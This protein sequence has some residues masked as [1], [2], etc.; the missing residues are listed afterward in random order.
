MKLFGSKINIGGKGIRIAAICLAAVLVL[1]AALC[2]YTYANS[3]IFMRVSAGDISLGGKTYDEALEAIKS[4]CASRYENA[5]ITIRLED[6]ATEVVSS[7]ELKLAYDAEKTAAAAMSFGHEGGFFARIGSVLKTI[8]AGHELE[9]SL[10][11]DEDALSFVTA[12]LAKHDIEPE[13]ASFEIKDEELFLYPKTDGKKL[14]C[15]FLA[16]EILRKFSEED[17]SDIIIERE[18]AE[19][20]LL[21]M[22]KVYSE[23][24]SEVADARIEKKENESVIVPEVLGIDYDL[25]AAKVAYESGH[26]ETIKIPLQIT[27]PKVRTKDLEANL[28][29]TTLAEVTTY[30]SPK[31]VE[32]TS[33]VRLAAKLVNGTVLNPGEEFSYNT[34]VGPRTKAR[35]FKEAQIFASGEVVDGIGGGICQVSSTIYMAA[36]KSNMEITERKNHSFYVDYAPKGEDATVVYGAIDFKFRNTSKYPIKIEATSVNNYIRIRIKGTEPDEKVTVKLTKKTLSTTPY[37]TV[38]KNS[39]TL[40]AGKT[41]VTQKGQEGLVMEVY[42]NVYDKNGKLISSKF[43]NKSSYK[44][45]P[46]IIMVGTG[47]SA[48][49]TKPEPSEEVSGIP[50]Q[51]PEEKPEEKPAEAP[52]EKPEE[53]PSETPEEKPDEKPSDSGEAAPEEPPAEEQE[54]DW[55]T[56]A[57]EE[58]ENN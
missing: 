33:N 13:D 10:R 52:E 43:E 16:G 17:Y 39:D 49:A 25:S 27:K 26:G 19:A 56:P 11:A 5:S 3:D 37:N 36:L 57:E 46:E 12:E 22:D 8:F 50:E 34:V 20:K 48:G 58:G 4:E 51:K 1:F 7:E 35:G 45:M 38:K 44:P 18:F 40:A 32:R 29:K 24:H 53:K 47:A 2:V 54:P 21:D 41:E 30:F 28:F 14:N 23:V 9:L 42:R 15:G 6:I 31:K 55:I